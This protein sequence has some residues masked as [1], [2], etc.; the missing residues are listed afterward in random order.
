MINKRDFIDTET[1]IIDFVKV[2]GVLFAF[3]GGIV[4]LI[5]LYIVFWLALVFVGN[6]FFAVNPEDR[7]KIIKFENY[8][9]FEGIVKHPFFS[10]KEEN[11][12]INFI[13]DKNEVFALNLT[14]DIEHITQCKGSKLCIRTINGDEFKLDYGIGY[15]INTDKLINYAS[16]CTNN[17]IKGE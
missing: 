8:Q 12:S 4:I 17:H 1:G 7:Y 11:C 10:E 14:T 3:I 13:N 16:S 15:Y 2:G 9:K 5:S 6:F